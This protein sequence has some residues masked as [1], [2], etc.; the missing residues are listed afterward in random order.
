[1]M[2]RRALQRPPRRT[3][4]HGLRLFLEFTCCLREMLRG[5]DRDGLGGARQQAHTGCRRCSAGEDDP[6]HTAAI[7]DSHG[8]FSL[9]RHRVQPVV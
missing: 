1:M 6:Q 2:M 5:S 7:E 9:N 3:A 4:G 8:L